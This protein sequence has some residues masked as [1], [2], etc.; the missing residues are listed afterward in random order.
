M[1][2]ADQT[3]DDETAPSPAT[4]RESGDEGVADVLEPELLLPAFARGI[5][6]FVVGYLL[7]L[8]VV[9][10]GPASIRGGLADVPA[11][12]AFVFYGAHNVPVQVANLGAINFVAQQQNPSTP[13]IVFWLLPIAVLLG[14]GVELGSR[15][16]ARKASA[17][18]LVTSVL[19]VSLGYTALAFLGTFVFRTKTMFEVSA[20]LYL[21]DAIVFGFA[22]PAV[23]VLLG[24]SATM[25]YRRATIDA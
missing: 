9:L 6:S 1:V 17:V 5:A 10:A 15:F 11:L 7:T 8:V 18:D 2:S 3:A 20:K 16:L 13:L 24:A 22:Y 25:L 14:T 12:I 23:F 19:A 21:G 4:Q